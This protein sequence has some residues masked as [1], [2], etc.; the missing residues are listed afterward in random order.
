MKEQIYQIMKEIVPFEDI[1][2]DTEL[3]EEGILDSLTLV[4]LINEIEEQM[5]VVIPEEEVRPE[6]FISVK[7]IELLLKQLR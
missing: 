2:D 5:N 6:N 7:A 4:L 1:T 3:F